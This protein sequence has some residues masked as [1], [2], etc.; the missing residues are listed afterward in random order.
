MN[1]MEDEV[2]PVVDAPHAHSILWKTRAH[3]KLA[4]RRA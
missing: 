3:G 4:K 1:G 2:I